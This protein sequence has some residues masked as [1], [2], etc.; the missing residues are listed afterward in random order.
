ML[1]RLEMKEKYNCVARIKRTNDNKIVL[2]PSVKKNTEV[3]Q[4]LY[5]AVGKYH[6]FI[7]IGQNIENTQLIN[8]ALSGDMM[9]SDISFLF[10]ILQKLVNDWLDE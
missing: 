3:D 6:N 4:A 7:L 1:S 10:M 2:L 9:K 5:D 8:Y